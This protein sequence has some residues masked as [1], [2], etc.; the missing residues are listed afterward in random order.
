MRA[1]LPT[2]KALQN[3]EEGRIE[4]ATMI[5]VKNIALSQA[6]DGTIPTAIAVQKETGALLFGQEALV[7]SSVDYDLLINWKLLLGKNLALLNKERAEND[8]L[9]R[10]LE[11][12]TLEDLAC[13]YFRHVVDRIIANVGITEKP[14]FI[15]GIPAVAD[16]LRGDWRARYKASIETVFTKLDL[17]APRFFPEPFAS[18]QRLDDRGIIHIKA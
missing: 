2:L 4:P 14:Q 3:W 11:H 13:A 15:V 10:I 1:I 5:P 12:Y 6:S 17:P 18:R 7:S 9:S 16:N 8:S